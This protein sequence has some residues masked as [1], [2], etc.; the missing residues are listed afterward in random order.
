MLQQKK[1]T[2][3]ERN[4]DGKA[5]YQEDITMVMLINTIQNIHDG[6]DQIAVEMIKALLNLLNYIRKERRTSNIGK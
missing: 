3:Q 2:T 5:R 1:E 4:D 6:R